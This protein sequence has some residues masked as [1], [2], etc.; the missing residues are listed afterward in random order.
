MGVENAAEAANMTV[1]TSG[2]GSI[3]SASASSIAIGVKM[4]PTA[5]FD[6]VSVSVEAST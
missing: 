1:T 4:T 6:T 3:P 5:L 2:L